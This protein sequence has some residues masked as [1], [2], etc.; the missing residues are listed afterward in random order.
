MCSGG[1][2][3]EGRTWRANTRLQAHVRL[4]GALSRYISPSQA[5][6]HEEEAGQASRHPPSCP[7][8]AA[9]SP[10]EPRQ[11]PPPP[12]RAP[13]QQG[14]QA[15]PRQPR[16][17]RPAPA[18]RLPQ[19]PPPPPPR[20]LQGP[21]QV[22]AQPG[23]PSRQSQT[24]STGPNVTKE[25][26]GSLLAILPAACAGA[27]LLKAAAATGRCPRQAGRG[28]ERHAGHSCPGPPEPG[29]LL[30]RCA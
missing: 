28:T 29:V 21:P 16:R 8:P 20:Q 19:A 11:P 4:A 10:A 24:W 6:A 17:R 23:T 22:G 3:S 27:C 30:L 7:E 5:A 25:A 15:Q 26:G 1:G 2:G 18:A 12:Q 9:W 13:P 14:L